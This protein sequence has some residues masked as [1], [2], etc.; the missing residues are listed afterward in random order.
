MLDLDKQGNISTT[1][2]GTES[3]ALPGC[4]A[5][6]NS[7]IDPNISQ[8]IQKSDQSHVDCIPGSF[9]LEQFNNTSPGDWEGTGLERSLVD[10]L[11]SKIRQ[12]QLTLLWPTLEDV[13]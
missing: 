3:V 4:E 13:A 12:V 11:S 9:Q 6:F 1:L 10:P 5:F 2:L 8:L 7:A